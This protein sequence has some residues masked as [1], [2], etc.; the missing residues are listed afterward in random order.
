MPI[1]PIKLKKIESNSKHQLPCLLGWQISIQSLLLIWDVLH[2]EYSVKY[3]LTNHLNQDCVENLFAII[4]NKGA[5][6]D[7]PDAS[8]VR[9]TF[10]KVMVDFVMVP[11]QHTQ[12]C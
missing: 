6:R 2:C 4:R 8:Q 7:N 1:K 9:A 11:G 3:L 10:R 5:Q 12:L